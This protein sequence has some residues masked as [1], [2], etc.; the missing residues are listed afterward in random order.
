VFDIHATAGVTIPHFSMVMI[1]Y[2]ERLMTVMLCPN[3]GNRLRLVRR[4]RWGSLNAH[5]GQAPFGLLVRRAK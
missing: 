4:P 3:S 5:R 2:I 1:Y